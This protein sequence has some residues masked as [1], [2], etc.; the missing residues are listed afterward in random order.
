MKENKITEIGERITNLGQ[1]EEEVTVD[2][3]R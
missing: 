1:E 3:K 2:L